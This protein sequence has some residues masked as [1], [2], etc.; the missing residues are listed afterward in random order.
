MHTT[1]AKSC[2]GAH[3]QPPSSHGR[4]INANCQSWPRANHH[5]TQELIND[6]GSVKVVALEQSQTESAA[7][8]VIVE[9][10]QCN[11]NVY[12]QCARCENKKVATE[13]T[14]ERCCYEVEND[15]DRLTRQPINQP[16]KF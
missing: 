14:E 3:A 1:S 4:L 15:E 8:V 13:E 10:P 12:V 7:V 6:E 11:M 2:S 16:T 9:E 5:L